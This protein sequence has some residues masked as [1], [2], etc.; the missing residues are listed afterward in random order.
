[1]R[2]HVHLRRLTGL[3]NGGRL[4]VTQADTPTAIGLLAS[5][6]VD[7]ADPAVLADFY[8]SLLGMQRIYESADGAVIALS[9]GGICVTATAS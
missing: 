6:S 4:T 7:C 9:G 1:M 3:C 8:G 5:I 2:G